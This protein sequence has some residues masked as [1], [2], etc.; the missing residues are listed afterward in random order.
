MYHCIDL[1][2]ISNCNPS[3]GL[4][5]GSLSVN[6]WGRAEVTQHNLPGHESPSK[7]DHESELQVETISNN[8]ISNFR[9]LGGAHNRVSEG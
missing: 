5:L 2:S 9:A 3:L 4:F 1:I 8:D 7:P 6:L